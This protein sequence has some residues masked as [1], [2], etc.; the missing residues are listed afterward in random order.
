MD[1]NR[2]N[3]MV[4]R[5]YGVDIADVLSQSRGDKVVV[6]RR[7][8]QYFARKCTSRS[9]PEIA[10]AFGKSPASVINAVKSVENRCSV[11]ADFR[12]EVGIMQQQ[13][14]SAKTT[15]TTVEACDAQFRVEDVAREKAIDSITRELAGVATVDENNLGL[16]VFDM[17]VKV[18]GWRQSRFEITTDDNGIVFC[19]KSEC[20]EFTV[21]RKTLIK[22]DENFWRIVSLPPAYA[23]GIG[24]MIRDFIESV[25]ETA[26][27]YR[28]LL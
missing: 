11:D 18:D 4:S 20:R 10:A 15:G 23:L 1:I 19:V 5:H 7:V 25:A 9:L 2:I 16:L 6:A 12:S 26:A 14:E 13:F 8:A 24:V 21:R 17:V 28:V 27:K 3:E 22:P